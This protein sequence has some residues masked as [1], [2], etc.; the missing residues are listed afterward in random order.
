MEKT[1]DEVYKE[2]NIC[3]A[4]LAVMALKLGLKVGIKKTEIEGWDPCWLNCV[5]IEIP[6][7]GQV[8]WHYHDRETILFNGL[9]EFVDEYDGHTTEDKYKIL[10]N[11]IMADLYNLIFPLVRKEYIPQESKV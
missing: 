8:S 7:H 1:I 5:Y 11:Y 10:T 9:P 3:V 4:A 6:Y 2:R